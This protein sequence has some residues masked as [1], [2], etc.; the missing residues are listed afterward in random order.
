MTTAGPVTE[1]PAHAPRELQPETATRVRDL[2]RTVG[3]A[4][5]ADAAADLV[6]P[7]RRPFQPRNGYE[8]VCGPAFGITTDDDMLP[9]LQA[10]AL[11]PAGSVLLVVN[12]REPSEALVGD[13]FLTSALVQGLGGVVVDGAVRDLADLREIA[14]PV[15][16]TAVTF[17]SAR[18]T[19]RRAPQVPCAVDVAGVTVAPGDWIFGDADGF[20][21]VPARHVNAVM[22]AGAVLRRRED[23]LRETMRRDLR[24]LADLTNLTGFLEGSGELGFV[25]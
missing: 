1:V 12:S 13:I 15:F 18:T 5:L 6:R 25:P 10:L 14:V 19:D 16:S 7:L 22:A 24:T 11:A 8:R 2:F 21:S 20:L 9:C 23:G 3:T 4:Q 17:V